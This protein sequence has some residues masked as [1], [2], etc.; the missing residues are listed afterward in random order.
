V[1]RPSGE[2][3]YEIK[4]VPGRSAVL[5]HSGNTIKD[6]QGCVLLGRNRGVKNG[7]PAV[8]DSRAAVADFM[9]AMGGEPFDL[10]I[11]GIA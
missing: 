5:I 9:A 11:S 7:I 1:T 6:I 8:L 4:D 10:E 2:K 3:A